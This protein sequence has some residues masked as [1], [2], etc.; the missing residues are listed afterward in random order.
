MADEPKMDLIVPRSK[1]RPD[2][3]QAAEQMGFHS[4][5]F[6]EALFSRTGFDWSGPKE[7]TDPDHFS[8]LATAAAATSRIRLGT[9][10]LSGP[11]PP[12]WSFATMMANIDRLSKGRISL[13]IS[14]GAWPDEGVRE[15]RR[16][17]QGVRLGENITALKSLWSE[18]AVSFKGSHLILD[19]ASI[20]VKPMQ[21]GGI[22]ILVGGV[23]SAS[24]NMAATFADGWV[25]PSGGIP[26]DAAP[27]C[28]F[29]RE[30]ASSTGRDSDSLELGKITYLSI[31][32]DRGRARNRIAPL[33]QSFYS[34]YDVDSWCAFG[35]PAECAAFIRGF[36]D[37][38]ITTV[39]LCLVPTDVEHLERLHL[40]V[41]PLLK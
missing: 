13:G 1:E 28:D 27:G 9:A 41:Q 17:R 35:P 23:T 10:E 16:P 40:A 36:L 39:M 8:V 14:R 22:P 19:N 3:Y 5:W 11:T 34:G 6:T 37:V 12:I 21:A 7:K 31:D 38:G 24:M 25:H 4:L 18:A 26:D 2:F 33:L 32:N 20:D 30:L 29:V 15:D